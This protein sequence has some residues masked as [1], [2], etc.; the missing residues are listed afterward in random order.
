MLRAFSEKL[1]PTDA[2]I[3]RLKA[4]LT[5]DI[6]SLNSELGWLID[7]L[8]KLNSSSTAHG[9]STVTEDDMEEYGESIEIM[10]RLCRAEI[11]ERV[12]ILNRLIDISLGNVR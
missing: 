10:R 1:S 8:D 9:I 7:I 3:S 5:S 6:S 2:A 11:S 12:L 4:E